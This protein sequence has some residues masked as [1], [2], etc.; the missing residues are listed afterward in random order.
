MPQAR[1]KIK[2]QLPPNQ[3]VISVRKLLHDQWLLP[4][5]FIHYLRRRRQ[6]LINGQYR[7]MNQVVRP[8]DLVKLSFYGD[9]FRTATSNYQ[10]TPTPRLQVLFENRDLMVVNKPAGQKTHPNQ[11][12][13]IGTLMN[14]VAGYLVGTTNGAY[15]VHRIDQATSGALIVAK[16]P[17][18]VPILDR[19]IASGQIHRE[20]LAA[21][22]GEFTDLTGQF[23]WPIGRDPHDRRK[24]K[25]DGPGA[26]PALTNYRVMATSGGQSLV[27][28]KLATGRTHQIRVHLAHSGHPIVGDPLYNPVPAQQMLLHGVAQRLV[29]PFTGKAVQI[30]APLPNYF[31][32]ALVKYSQ[33]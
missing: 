23:N 16:N 10:P 4:S 30:S 1:W 12:L 25:V 24:R 14:D 13:E 3:E 17:V 22:D 15:M 2:E 26:Q 11:P 9:E 19:L 33:E 5:R 6:V 7:S 29:L 20:Y 31:P 32:S 8:G 21:V 28:L 18:V 27:Q